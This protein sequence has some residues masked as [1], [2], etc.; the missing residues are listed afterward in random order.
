MDKTDRF[1]GS[2]V[3]VGVVPDVIHIEILGV[4]HIGHGEKHRLEFPIDAAPV[5]AAAK[6]L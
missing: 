6:R 4:I 5:S 1:D 3:M 2:L